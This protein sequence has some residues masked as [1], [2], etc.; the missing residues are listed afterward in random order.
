MQ[1]QSDVCQIRLDYD[2]HTI[3]DPQTAAQ[4][5]TCSID[6]FQGSNAATGGG[7]T[8]ADTTLPLVHRSQEKHSVFS[9][10]LRGERWPTHLPGRRQGHHQLRLPH[11]RTYWHLQQGMEDQGH[12]GQQGATI[13]LEQF[14]IF[15]QILCSACLP[16]GC[17]QYHTGLTGT[18]RSFNFNTAGTY[19]HLA[20]QFYKGARRNLSQQNSYTVLTFLPVLVTAYECSATL[21]RPASG[22]RKATARLPG[23][24]GLL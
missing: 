14:S 9:A 18:V 6:Y 5:G 7:T 23:H 24:R 15:C 1:S 12:P 13:V 11:R 17:Y 10:A 19:N 2:V 16:A 22:V 20:S 21:A 3:A 4:A 8:A